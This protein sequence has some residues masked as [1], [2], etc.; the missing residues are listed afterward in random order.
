LPPV[1]GAATAPDR[2]L[3]GLDEQARTT[4]VAVREEDGY[5]FDVLLQGP[6]ETA[7]FSV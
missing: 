7:F 1:F 3:S 6:D 2:V 4:L 5:R